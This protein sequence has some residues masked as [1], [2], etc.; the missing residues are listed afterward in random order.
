MDKKL[1]KFGMDW[2]NG[3]LP[4]T[5][6]YGVFELLGKFS[7]KLRFERWQL[8][9][10]GKYNY[11]RRYCLDGNAT[12][13]L[14]YNPVSDE[15]AFTACEPDEWIEGMPKGEKKAGTH[16]NPYI[17]FSISGDGIR[18]LHSLSGDVSALNKLLFYFYRHSFRASRFDVYCDIL[19]SK[20]EIVPLLTEAFMYFGQEQPGKLALATKVQ[21]KRKN[22]TMYRGL[23]DDG[24]EFW[25]STLGNHGTRFGMF[26]CYNKYV[27][28]TDGRLA[29]FSADVFKSYDIDDYWY[30]LE[31]EMHK[32]NA[33]A[34]FDA[35]M[36]R[37]ESC[38]T[39]LC[40]EDIFFSVYERVF[41]VVTAKSFGYKLGDC[42]VVP[43]WAAFGEELSSSNEYFVQFRG[44]PY[45]KCSISRLDKNMERISS[46]MYIMMLRLFSMPKKERLEYM[47]RG[48]DKFK[49]NKKYNLIRDEFD[50][51]G[52]TN[53]SDAIFNAIA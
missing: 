32:E 4:V 36:E 27:E 24:S 51:L 21:H 25:N 52:V 17:F 8:T 12:I 23:N 11:R 22:V 1:Y 28:M 46:Y 45:I 19:D 2:L 6:V 7:S 37:A 14:M 50:D 20:N 13:Q 26:R 53:L 34:C 38:N 39:P 31:Y 49:Q 40:F 30:R 10:S 9:N 44:V 5:D 47:I 48:S 42:E 29:D 43:A 16:H 15:E 3:V 33:S 18:Y 35:L 41:K